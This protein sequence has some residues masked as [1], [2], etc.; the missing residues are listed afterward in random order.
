MQLAVGGQAL[1]GLDASALGLD[2]QHQA[3]ADEATV[4]DDA[5][6]PAV[7]RAA[8]FLRA[9]EAE[10]VAQRVEQRRARIG[11]EFGGV[12]VDGGG[13]VDLAHAR[14]L[15]LSKAIW[16]ARRASTPA[17]LVRYS[18]VPRLSLMGLQ[19]A[20]AAASRASSAAGSSF[21]PT[22]AWPAAVTSRQVGAT[23]PSE[24]CAS[25]I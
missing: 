25:R 10:L 9:G 7:A 17:I 12:A 5:A 13:D 22:S 23:A 6:G 8:A 19:A 14:A 16:A 24:T 4:D 3:R 1:D 2:R 18:A 21:E 15:A 11:E 20:R